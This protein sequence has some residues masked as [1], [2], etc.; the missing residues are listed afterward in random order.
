MMVIVSEMTTHW[1]L[2]SK[3]FLYSKLSEKLKGCPSGAQRFFC[4]VY[5][6]IHTHT[7]HHTSAMS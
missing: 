2:G 5:T 4:T 7:T 3:F 1:E 6:H